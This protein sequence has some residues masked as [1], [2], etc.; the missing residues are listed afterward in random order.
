MQQ[1]YGKDVKIYCITVMSVKLRA[2]QAG[3]VSLSIA[4]DTTDVDIQMTN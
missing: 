3:A 2:D 4:V 1:F